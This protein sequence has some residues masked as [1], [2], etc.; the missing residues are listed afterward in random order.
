MIHKMYK[1]SIIKNKMLINGLCNNDSNH[2]FVAIGMGL[3]L[4]WVFK[5]KLDTK[6]FSYCLF[7]DVKRMLILLIIK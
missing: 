5:P 6:F 4:F 2:H 1:I 7:S 3:K